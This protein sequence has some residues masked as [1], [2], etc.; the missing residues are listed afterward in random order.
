MRHDLINRDLFGNE[1]GEDEDLDILNSYFVDKP[2]FK[3]F[4]S[5]NQHL[6]FV[7]SRKGVGKSALLKQTLYQRQLEGKDEILIYLKASDLIALQE[8]SSS[9]PATQ[10][11]GW[12]QRICSRINLEI[13]ATLR[14]GLTDGAIALIEGAELNGF[15]DRNIVSALVDRLKIKGLGA[16]IERTRVTTTN[17]QALLSRILKSQ[18]VR[19]WLLIDDVD[20]T[21][22]NTEQERLVT[23]TFFSACRNLINSVK[24]L[25]IR[26][27]VR[28]D[29]WP[30][31][32]QHDE[33]LDKCEQYMLDLQWSTVESG[34]ILE[35]KIFSY[36][37]R[38]YPREAKYSHLSVTRDA[39]RIR[40]LIFREPFRWSGRPLEAF[41]PIHILSA[42]RPRWAAQLCK[43]AGR[44]AYDKS[45]N[46]ISMGHVRDSLREYG[47]SRV[48]D[49]YKEHRHQCARIEG[50]I[51]T[52]SGGPTRYTTNE[53]LK[54]L[55]ERLIKRHGLPNI[56]GIVA[57]KGSVTVAHFLYR[58]GFIAA[59]DESDPK[60]LEFVRYED[61]PNLLSTV[62][63][64]DD[65]MDWE[66]H[67]S[68]R[69]VLRI[70]KSRDETE[71]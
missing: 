67:P 64:L 28:T 5:H 43:L 66:I 2:D 36:F 34:K 22:I 12:Q 71:D 31:L 50:I 69:Q 44:D 55:T 53:L 42:G 56:D 26:A 40:Q 35:N 59:R 46:H 17:P 60:T 57:E 15:R 52:F 68:Y 14:I 27:A 37:K 61:R 65:G 23:C 47:K 25:C 16:E 51:E 39:G 38:N 30:I 32:A 62:A 11:Y 19:V 9:S 58:I 41:R 20:A 13:G 33:S 7:R 63:N 6:H 21:F 49:L 10:V 3:D 29:V 45:T 8:I 54:H 70:K 48:S 18:D 4:F 24:G 1:A